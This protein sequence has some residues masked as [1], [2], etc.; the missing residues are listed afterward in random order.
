M[1]TLSHHTDKELVR[2]YVEGLNE[3][4][5][6]LLLRHKDRLFGYILTNVH[7]EDLANDI[8][9]ETFFKAI[10]FLRKGRY[11]DNEKFYVWLAR[12]A[13][14]VMID[15]F[16]KQQTQDSTMSCKELE[17]MTANEENL[18]NA[19]ERE[20][21]YEKNLCEVNDLVELLPEAQQDIVRMYYFQNMSFKEIAAAQNICLNTALGR[22]HYAIHN[23]RKMANMRHFHP[24]Q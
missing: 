11:E 20:R 5:D 12:I 8:F 4:F 22:M 15:Q 10:V 6:T 7:D 21:L 18:S 19:E 13:H 1:K 24:F 2:M 23:M 17:W 14:N 9:Q 16:R 3:A